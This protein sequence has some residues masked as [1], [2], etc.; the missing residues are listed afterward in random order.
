LL[1]AILIAERAAP[2]AFKR[3]GPAA[4]DPAPQRRTTTIFRRA[5]KG[6]LQRETK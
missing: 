6:A 2:A 5:F 3:V 4:S 1:V